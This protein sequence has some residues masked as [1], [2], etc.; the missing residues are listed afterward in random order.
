MAISRTTQISVT[1]TITAGAYSAGDAVGGLLTFALAVNEFVRTGRIVNV[2]V[3][4]KAGESADIDL[5]LFD[6][7]FTPTA[8]NAAWP[9]TSPAEAFI[10]SNC[11]GVVSVVSG[12]YAA[13]SG[14]TMAVVE[15]DMPIVL[16]STTLY[17]QAV[18]RDT[19]TYAATDDLTFR[20]TIA[21]D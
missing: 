8:D 9:T 12:D 13:Y 15:V 7:T 14:G 3:I 4:D 1:P 10:G 21:K 18:T 11:I 19:P 16:A 2:A 5:F 17:A 20:L 6:A